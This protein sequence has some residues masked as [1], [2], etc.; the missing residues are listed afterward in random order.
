ME[1]EF[2]LQQPTTWNSS[3]MATNDSNSY[4]SHSNNWDSFHSALTSVAPPQRTN[5]GINGDI[6]G[7]I[8]GISNPNNG[9]F[10]AT[11]L[12]SPPNP[13][14]NPN[15]APSISSDPGFAE[16]AARFSKFG[17]R[18]FNG[19]QGGLGIGSGPESGKF[20]RVSSCQ[21]LKFPGSNFVDGIQIPE[22]KLDGFSRCAT[23]EKGDSKEESS[24]SEQLPGGD[25]GLKSASQ[26]DLNP[27]KRKSIPKGKKEI[28]QI[29]ED[30]GNL[31]GYDTKRTKSDES[32]GTEKSGKN[33]IGKSNGKSKD[34]SKNNSEPPKD[35]I[36]VRARRGQATDSHSLAERVR[37]EKISQRMKFLQDLVPGC[38]KVTGKAVMLDEIINYVQSLQRQV[39]FLSMKLSTVNPR[40]D[41][42]VEALLSKDLHQARS[43]LSQSLFALESNPVSPA[44]PYGYQSQGPLVQNAHSN[45]SESSFSMSPLNTQ[46]P[47]HVV[48]LPSSMDGFDQSASQVSMWI[49]EL[50]NVVQMG[51]GQNEQQNFQGSLTSSDMKMEQ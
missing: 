38:N 37:R 46:R 14:R 11:P 24:V 33:A 48:Q 10:H 28:N 25:L 5:A 31:D 21:A 17:S 8:S 20:P 40:A 6:V 43:L 32:N 26:K 3:N 23:P 44:F 15:L 13:T 18:S 39:E 29:Q 45:E 47:N 9:S 49:D 51:Y 12:H 7:R 1:K 16:R 41:V 36:H 22:R 42:N 35:Y 27:R 30:A 50:H 19:Q 34:N 2:Y 4:F